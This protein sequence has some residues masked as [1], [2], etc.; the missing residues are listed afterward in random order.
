MRCRKVLDILGS[1]STFFSILIFLLFTWQRPCLN[2]LT[3]LS[4]DCAHS[5]TIWD[6][7][8][9]NFQCNCIY[10]VTKFQSKEKL[11]TNHKIG[12]HWKKIWKIKFQY[13]F[14]FHQILNGQYMTCPF[15]SNNIVSLPWIAMTIN[16]TMFHKTWTNYHTVHTHSKGST[17]ITYKYNVKWQVEVVIEACIVYSVGQV[18][19]HVHWNYRHISNSRNISVSNAGWW[20]SRYKNW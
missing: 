3:V 16:T 6:A 8:N 20:I 14:S 15:F 11:K 12:E 5:T 4:R 7:I 18:G 13:F 10:A 17:W 19:D 2:L 1:Y 9:F